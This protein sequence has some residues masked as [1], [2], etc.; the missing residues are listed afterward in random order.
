MRA[1]SCPTELRRPS[2]AM[3]PPTP[4]TAPNIKASS[5]LQ[6]QART[7]FTS[8]WDL[9]RQSRKKR[10]NAPLSQ[11]R[12]QRAPCISQVTSPQLSLRSQRVPLTGMQHSK[13]KYRFIFFLIPVPC[14]DA[15]PAPLGVLIDWF[16]D[17]TPQ[18][19]PNDFCGDSPRAQEVSPDKVPSVNECGFVTRRVRCYP[20]PLI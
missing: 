14:P 2:T 16:M 3:Q 11:T 8:P 12:E 5:P 10:P 17:Q 15:A 9:L 7:G 6:P 4:T 20:E 19:P 1:V 13:T 18:G